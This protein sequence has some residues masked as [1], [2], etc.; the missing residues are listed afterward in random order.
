MGTLE[1]VASHTYLHCR[2]YG[3]AAQFLG[4]SSLDFQATPGWPFFYDIISET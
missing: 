4:V 3:V 2:H 1:G